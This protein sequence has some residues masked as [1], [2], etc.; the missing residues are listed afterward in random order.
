MASN[1][2]QCEKCQNQV[3]GDARHCDVCKKELQAER[4]RLYHFNRRKQRVESGLCIECGGPKD[5]PSNLTKYIK[6]NADPK[7]V[8]LIS[9]EQL[10]A[11][12]QCYICYIAKKLVTFRKRQEREA[13]N[14]KPRL[15]D[16]QKET[17]RKKQVLECGRKRRAE[18]IANN[19]NICHHC[20]KR[21]KAEGKKWCQ[22]CLDKASEINNA[23]IRK[24]RASSA[25]IVCAE[26]SFGQQ[27]CSGCKEL[28]KQYSHKWWDKVRQER[29]DKGLCIRCGNQ[30]PEP[31]KKSC[32]ECSAK[33]QKYMKER[34]GQR[35]CKRC[36]KNPLGFKERVCQECKKAKN[37]VPESTAIVAPKPK[38]V[39]MPELVVK[40]NTAPSVSVLI[41]GTDDEF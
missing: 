11:S 7:L 25:C 37:Q 23:R 2:K 39:V 22:F 19:P 27:L 8:K 15:T 12:T 13:N 34:N 4:S 5:L 10:I 41:N 9:K 18:L 3:E 35:I 24:R 28:Q 29:E 21:D 30:P 31:Y 16:K 17:I 33:I 40:V 38:P 6:E 26:E 1:T 20:L 14:P 36:N 32:A